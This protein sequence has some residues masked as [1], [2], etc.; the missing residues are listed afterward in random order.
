MTFRG[1]GGLMSGAIR[2][3]LDAS[4]NEIV[5]VL[6]VTICVFDAVITW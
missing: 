1:F 5:V 6:I 3:L 2:R 4:E